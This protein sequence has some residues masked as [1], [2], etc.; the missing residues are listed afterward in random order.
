MNSSGY[1]QISPELAPERLGAYG[2]DSDQPQLILARYLLN[3]ALCE[4]LYSP[5]QMAEI[6]QQ[7]S[8]ILEAIHWISPKLAELSKTLDRYTQTRQAGLK[9]W[10][11]QIN[12]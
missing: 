6:G 8:E 9:P 5:L 1:D 11:D 4:S 3:M 7:H 12:R 2:T 10:I